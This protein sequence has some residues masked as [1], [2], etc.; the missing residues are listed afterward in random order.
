M[1]NG[2]SSA[3]DHP[4]SLSIRTRM[5]R[6][7]PCDPGRASTKSRRYAQADWRATS[8]RG[9]RTK[10]LGARASA[11]FPRARV[12][13][14]ASPR[15]PIWRWPSLAHRCCAMSQS[16]CEAS[17]TR[18]MTGAGPSKWQRASAR[19]I[20][21]WWPSTV[22][23]LRWMATARWLL[24]SPARRSRKAVGPGSIQKRALATPGGA[25]SVS[26]DRPEGRVVGMVACTVAEGAMTRAVEA[27]LVVLMVGYFDSFTR[28]CSCR[29][30]PAARSAP[31]RAPAR[32][33]CRR[34]RPAAGPSSARR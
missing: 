5:S 31:C 17:C 16:I 29:H 9:L 33:R 20:S 1:S 34:R 25:I 18:S 8:P 14:S 12:C 24:I 19:S 15:P 11:P 2:A 13:Q 4:G 6:V 3:E 7:F 27:V 10:V 23:S 32:A 26:T 28:S 30:Q 21:P 22:R